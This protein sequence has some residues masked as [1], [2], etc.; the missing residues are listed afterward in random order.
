MAPISSRL[1]PICGLLV[2]P[3]FT[4]GWLVGG[5]A[6]PAS[7]SWIRHDISDLGAMTA[8]QPW[9]YNQIGANLTGLLLLAF[10]VGLWR[11]LGSSRM[12]RA[13]VSLLAIVAI[14]QFLDG[15]LRLDCRALDPGCAQQPASWH[16][17]AHVIE[18]TVTIFSLLV[19]PFVF[20]W[21]LRRVSGWA[22]LSRPT[23]LFGVAAIVAVF[24]LTILA[25]GIGPRAA[26]TIWFA[27]VALLAYRLLRLETRSPDAPAG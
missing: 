11:A 23:L 3:V 26:A 14:D 20:A 4:F 8:D 5:L 22:D 18:S 6:Q 27:W 13:G 19:V 16:A 10:A 7:Y 9:I 1:A 21:A 12:A 17:V 2:L 25:E 15:F 24:G